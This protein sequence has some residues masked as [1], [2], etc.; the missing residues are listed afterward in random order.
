EGS[1]LA[2]HKPELLRL[3][4][5][6]GPVV[7]V[8]VLGGRRLLFCTFDRETAATL[9]IR[10]ALWELAFYGTLALTVAA[11]VH[12]TGTLFV[13]GFLVLPGASGIVLGRSAVGVTTTAVVVALVSAAAGFVLSYAWD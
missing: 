2:V 5:A 4:L 12:A 10:T 7:L 6:L 13:F 11:G 8:H 1:I 3:S 9:G